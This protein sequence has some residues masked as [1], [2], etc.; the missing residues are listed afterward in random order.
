MQ[1]ARIVKPLLVSQCSVSNQPQGASGGNVRE[2]GE[3]IESHCQQPTNIAL[4]L[5][6]YETLDA[7]AITDEIVARQALW[8]LCLSFPR[9]GDSPEAWKRAMADLSMPSPAI[10]VA[11]S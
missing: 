3:G 5:T 8:D 4:F 1:R 9:H 7:P 2:K 6:T 10:L 11:S